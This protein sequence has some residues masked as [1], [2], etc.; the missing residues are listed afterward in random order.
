MAR[1]Q[2][3]KNHYTTLTE[4]LRQKKTCVLATVAEAHGSTPQKAGS[5]A[6]FTSEGLFTGTIGGGRVEHCV[7]EKALDALWTKISEIHRF[8]LNDD[9]EEENSV[10]CGGGMT[11]FTDASPEKH[12]EVFEEISEALAARISGVLVTLAN[13]VGR[14]EFNLKRYWITRG[15]RNKATELLPD[16]VT[17]NL[18]EMLDN[19][20]SDDFR[21]LKFT[22]TGKQEN[23]FA[24][25]ESIVPLPR[26][27]I[28]GAGHV[29]KALVHL[30]KLLDFEV[31]VWDDRHEFANGNNLPEADLILTGELNTALKDI[32][33]MQ[34]TFIVIVTRG[35]KQDADVLKLFID[36]DAGYI[37]MI[38][39][40]KKIA[41]VR[42]Q[43]IGKGWATEERW[44]NIHAPIGLDIHSTSVQEIA[45][46]IAAQ[47]IQERYNLKRKNG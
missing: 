39:S 1:T 8:E 7:Q 18:N 27:I 43:F 3:C 25:L 13:P 31:I 11:I 5:S 33:P 14:E 37:G 17:Q 19:A 20:V 29:G 35:H 38:G 34:D 32:T 45:V 40:R 36:S 26:L 22:K 10:I 12:L 30:G 6:L 16:R 23:N 47:L 9:I 42:D 24:F 15:N 2:N 44:S 28:A 4:L 21:K 41:Q 46:S